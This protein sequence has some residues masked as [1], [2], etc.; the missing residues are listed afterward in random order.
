MQSGPYLL[1]R[2]DHANTCPTPG[3]HQVVPHSKNTI[4]DEAQTK[5]RTL[6]H[7]AISVLMCSR[8]LVSLE[9]NRMRVKSSMCQ[10][11][12]HVLNF[13]STKCCGETSIVVQI[14]RKEEP[15]DM[16]T[17]VSL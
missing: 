14:R 3:V 17:R 7:N 4:P 8:D 11:V 9:R 10:F 13:F 6:F 5:T 15:R 1:Q 2:I 12:R 16:N